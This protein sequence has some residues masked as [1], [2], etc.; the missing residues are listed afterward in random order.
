MVS[1]GQELELAGTIGIMR[2]YGISFSLAQEIET[3]T[4]VEKRCYSMRLMIT[5]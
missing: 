3:A 1:I 2:K 5:P 4:K